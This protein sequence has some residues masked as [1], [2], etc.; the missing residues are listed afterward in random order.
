MTNVYKIIRVILFRIFQS[1]GRHKTTAS[2]GQQQPYP[3]L[4]GGSSSSTFAGQFDR[5]TMHFA[6][7]R[8]RL[9]PY[10][11]FG[12]NENESVPVIV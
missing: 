6:G 12:P 10:F 11:A 4:V 1:T 5:F 9:L 8:V 7:V 3:L 2:L